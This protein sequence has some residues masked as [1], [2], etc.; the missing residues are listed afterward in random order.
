MTVLDQAENVGGIVSAAR[1]RERWQQEMA[2]TG[3]DEHRE[4]LRE[5][6]GTLEMRFPELE[7]IG[8]GGAEKFA[9]ERGHG[10]GSRSPSHEGRSRAQA[11]RKPDAAP[12]EHAARKAG[13]PTHGA[14]AP[15]G[16]R[17]T[18][19]DRHTPAGR[20]RTKRLE[21][22]ARSRGQQVYRETRIPAGGASISRIA[23]SALGG[24][25]GL[26]ALYLLLTTAERNGGGSQILS[27]LETSTGFL[28][29]IIAPVDF[30]GPQ[31]TQRD[32]AQAIASPGSPAAIASELPQLKPKPGMP[33]HKISPELRRETH[34][35]P[36]ALHRQR[37]GR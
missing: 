27:L 10:R 1:Q 30:F 21:R 37:K 17:N 18:K 24:T 35:L 4:A 25:V 31:L 8:P 9:R 36:Q 20:S 34:V 14:K 19:G 32:Y 23:M 5:G 3:D 15:A 6:V 33:V 26:S 29:R 22:R 12:L 13:K 2:K 7:E 28:R 16:E 11:R